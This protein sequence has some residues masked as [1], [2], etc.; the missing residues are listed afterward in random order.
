MKIPARRKVEAL[1]KLAKIS[2]EKT[3]DDYF[4]EYINKYQEILA[5]SDLEIE[6]WLRKQKDD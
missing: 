4:Q 3:G 2:L 1:L 5:K 6:E